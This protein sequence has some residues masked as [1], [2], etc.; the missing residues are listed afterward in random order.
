[1]Y[2]A[3]YNQMIDFETEYVFCKDNRLVRIIFTYLHT[4]IIGHF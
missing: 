1:M 2:Y 4:W 3:Q